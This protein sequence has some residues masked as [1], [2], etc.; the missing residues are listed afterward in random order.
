MDKIKSVYIKLIPSKTVGKENHK[1][2]VGKWVLFLIIAL[3]IFVFN[4]VIKGIE[5]QTNMFVNANVKYPYA[6]TSLIRMHDGNNPY[7][8]RYKKGTYYT[9]HS[10]MNAN[11]HYNNE[12]DKVRQT[13]IDNR[14]VETFRLF[15]QASDDVDVKKSIK[16]L[17]ALNKSE[18]RKRSDIRNLENQYDTMLFEKIAGQDKSLSIRNEDKIDAQS[19]KEKYNVLLK[20]KSDLESR[21]NT[22]HGTFSNISTIEIF[23]KYVEENRETILTDYKKEQSWGTAKSSIVA[24]LLALPLLIIFYLLLSRSLRDNN[25]IKYL[26]YKNLYV[27]MLII[28]LGYLSVIIYSVMPKTFIASLIGFFAQIQLPIIVYYLLVAL[29]VFIFS[30][31]I[32]KIYKRGEGKRLRHTDVTYYRKSLCSHCEECV[33]YETMNFCP[34]CKYTLK[35]ECTDC[36]NKTLAMFKYCTTCAKSEHETDRV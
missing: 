31:I 18:N 35:R 22:L 26:I 21:I 2:K 16:T 25:H 17:R 13:Y 32:V 8:Y 28:A 3:D 15:N 30:W 34:S 10:V 27:V 14:C 5:S 11:K 7:T 9:D 4:V 1:N 20:E 6:C 12:L 36:G 23:L 29:A 33:N 24:F 19:V